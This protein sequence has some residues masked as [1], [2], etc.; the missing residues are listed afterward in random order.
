MPAL[1][2]PGSK[3]SILMLQT[4]TLGWSVVIEK[5]ILP[6]RD[7]SIGPIITQLFASSIGSAD[8]TIGVSADA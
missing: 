6:F 1:F 4:L 2:M 7:A 5:G 8:L 3:D